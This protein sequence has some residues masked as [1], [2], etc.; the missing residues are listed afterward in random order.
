MEYLLFLAAF[1]QLFIGFQSVEDIGKIDVSWYYFSTIMITGLIIA[2][3]FRRKYRAQQVE[4]ERLGM[5][6][7][8]D[9][10]RLE[11]FTAGGFLLDF[12]LKFF[13]HTS[14]H[15]SNSSEILIILSLAPL[16]GLIM[17]RVDVRIK[18]LSGATLVFCMTLILSGLSPEFIYFKPALDKIS[19]ETQNSENTWKED[20][21]PL[22]NFKPDKKKNR[23]KR[24][25]VSLEKAP[26]GMKWRRR[27]LPQL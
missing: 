23:L 24:F 14:G 4:A 21:E 26:Q 6:L 12:L 25:S 13:V 17:D 1:I 20:K 16:L 15:K 5:Q 22:F 7:R 27:P 3:A 2:V 11:V 10:F 19:G 9:L 18:A 8:F